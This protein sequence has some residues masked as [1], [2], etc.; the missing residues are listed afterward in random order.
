M[1]AFFERPSPVDGKDAGSNNGLPLLLLRLSC[2]RHLA[3]SASATDAIFAIL[4]VCTPVHTISRIFFAIA[5]FFR[6]RNIFAEAWRATAAQRR[7]PVPGR[8][9]RAGP[10]EADR[11][12]GRWLGGLLQVG[13]NLAHRWARRCDCNSGRRRLRRRSC[14]CCARNKRGFAF[15]SNGTHKGSAHQSAF[16]PLS[17]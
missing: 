12:R 10:R 14:C 8:T 11:D 13:L 1:I 7:W 16:I 4:F 5:T 9:A 2:S 15:P 3:Y 17:L 6:N